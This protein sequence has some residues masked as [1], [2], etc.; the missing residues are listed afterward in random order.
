MEDQKKKTWLGQQS[1]L[2]I[3]LTRRKLEHPQA[4]NEIYRNIP[5]VRVAKIENLKK[6]IWNGTYRIDA[7]K[8]AEKMLNEF[9]IECLL[10]TN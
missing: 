7:E 3:H 4:I 10:D 9:S 1:V 2:R 5:E 8:I 6:A